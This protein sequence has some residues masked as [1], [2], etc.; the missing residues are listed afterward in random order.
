MR[1]F[2]WAAAVLAVVA[3]VEGTWA[4]WQIE[5]TSYNRRASGQEISRTSSTLLVSKDRVRTD[6][7]ISVTIFDYDKDSVLWLLPAKKMYWDGTSD[8]YLQQARRINP[9]SRLAPGKMKDLPALAMKVEETA[10]SVEIAGK[11]AKKYAIQMDGY[12][13]QDL[14]VAAPFGLE[15]DL[16]MRR[17]Q[18]MQ[19]KLAQ[20]MR[21]GYGVALT[22][23]QKD[24][25]YQRISTQGFP[26]RTHSYLGEAIV[27]TEVVALT[28][29]EIPDSEFAVPKGFKRV[30][31]V[32]LLDELK[33]PPPAK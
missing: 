20:G 13:F 16:D 6:D 22:A 24:E 18:A 32:Q 19:L 23:L 12:P 33:E 15:K 11:A 9:K 4:G 21:S 29:K 2:S 1:G 30:P 28:P 10:E 8:E 14:W 7:G 5:Q 25:L 27:G 31:L 26:L 17:F 3:T